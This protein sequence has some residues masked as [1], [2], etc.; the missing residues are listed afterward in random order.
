MS[1]EKPI[2]VN[3]DPCGFDPVFTEKGQSSCRIC[4]CRGISEVCST[5]PCFSYKRPERR[6]IHY[7]ESEVQNEVQ[8]Q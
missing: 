1:T 4:K 7:V 8:A 5:A 2:R 3:G 6:H